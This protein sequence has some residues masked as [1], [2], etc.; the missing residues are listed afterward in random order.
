MKAASRSWTA[1]GLSALLGA[2]ACVD[3]TS[4]TGL[5]LRAVA[6]LAVRPSFSVQP[7]AGELAS[8]SLARV[9]A[10]DFATNEVLARVEREIDPTAGEWAFDLTVRLPSLT[11]QV[12]LTVELA[13]DIVEWSGRS[14]PMPVAPGAEPAEVRVVSLARGPLDNLAVSG[15]AVVGAADSVG[16]GSVGLLQSVLEGGGPDSR[17]FY[18]SLSPGVLE[19]TREGAFRAVRPGEGLVEARAGMVA[20]TVLISVLSRPVDEGDAKTVGDGVAD[21]VDR[22]V[23]ALQDGPGAAAISRSLADFE[24]ALRSRRP[25]LIQ[26][27]LA[28]ARQAVEAYGTPQIRYQDGPELSLITLVLDYTERVVLGALLGSA[29]RS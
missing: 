25:A 2:G 3:G 15:V 14:A 19:V 26:D 11:H 10:V 17:A 13:S 18:R 27:A 28:A 7:A 22:L 23:P 21:S 6:G 1:L 16:E 24:E 9:V 20:D 5:D 4:P 29:S 8:L 12:V